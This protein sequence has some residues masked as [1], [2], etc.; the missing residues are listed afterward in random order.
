M[1][2]KPYVFV[3][4][5]PLRKNETTG[6]LE[7]FLPIERARAWGEVVKLSPDGSPGADPRSWMR[8]IREK[9]E[10]LWEDGDFVVLV[11]EQS[12]LAYAAAIVGEYVERCRAD[13][14]DNASAEVPTIRLLKWDRRANE[15]APLILK[16]PA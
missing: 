15:Y 1:S 11:G 8:P 7:R 12:M 10:E 9:L 13:A 6:E 16:E 2:R 14:V 5:E 3:V 4:N